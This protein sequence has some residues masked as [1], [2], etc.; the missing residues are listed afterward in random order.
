MTFFKENKKIIVK[1]I[2]THLVMTMFGMMVFIPFNKDDMSMKAFLIA[3]SVVAIL[4]YM[5]LIDVDMWYVGAEDKLRVDAGRQKRNVGKGFLIALIAEIP[6]IVVGVIYAVVSMLYAY[7]QAY[8]AGS[9]LA[10]AKI[11]TWCVTFI[12][13]GMYLGTDRVLFGGGVPLVYLIA[14]LLPIAFSGLT[15]WLGLINSPFLKPPARHKKQ[16]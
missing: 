13:N 15:Y 16:N 14:P 6:S 11:I 9:A 10:G 3:G 12:W 4:L 7:Y 8:P 1:L 2:L 5:F